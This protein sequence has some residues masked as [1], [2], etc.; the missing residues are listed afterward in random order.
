M[1]PFCLLPWGLPSSAWPSSP[2]QLLESLGASLPDLDLPV[3]WGHFAVPPLAPSP[4]SFPR[5][6]FGAPSPQLSVSLS[7][8]SCHCCCHSLLY[9][10]QPELC[11]VLSGLFG[12]PGGGQQLLG[13]LQAL[14]HEPGAAQQLG[15][16]L[17]YHCWASVLLEAWPGGKGREQ[18]RVL[19]CHEPP[20]PAAG[21]HSPSLA[22]P[23]AAWWLL[24]AAWWHL[25]RRDESRQGQA[26]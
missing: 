7:L 14:C 19:L 2:A 22:S 20:Q 9:S 3:P 8:Q 11:W 1:E 24:A 4:C 23:S 18:L 17:L 16:A 26:A 5:G 10:Q 6:L 12:G 13:A 25:W 15:H 21:P